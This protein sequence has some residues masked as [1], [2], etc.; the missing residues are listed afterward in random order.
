M[1]NK[2]YYDNANYVFVNNQSY[3]CFAPFRTPNYTTYELPLV[4]CK[5]KA[6]A[7][8]E[9]LNKE[10]PFEWKFKEDSVHI[11]PPKT[12][13]KFLILFGNLT[14]GVSEF[15]FFCEKHLE[16]CNG[17]F[18]DDNLKAFQQY[19]IND[20]L[21]VGYT[22]LHGWWEYSNLEKTTHKTKTI[23]ELFEKFENIK[24]N[25]S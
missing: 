2:Y 9:L 4:L 6:Q 3:Y 8:L 12:D 17:N 1:E 10:I 19:S 22:N 5:E 15:A 18:F 21:E 7:W 24:S 16:N 11:K 25:L 23:K 14:K 20:L 13:F